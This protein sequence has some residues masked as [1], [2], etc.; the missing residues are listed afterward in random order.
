MFRILKDFVILWALTVLT[1]GLNK[2]DPGRPN[3]YWKLTIGLRGQEGGTGIGGGHGVTQVKIRDFGAWGSV[4][5]T[6]TGRRVREEEQLIA[7]KGSDSQ[8]SYL[9]SPSKRGVAVSS[10]PA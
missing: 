1:K 9:K 10:P 3:A 4:I 8:N 5:T 2:I 6:T 7:K